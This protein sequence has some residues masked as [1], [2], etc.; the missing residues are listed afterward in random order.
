MTSG[1][2]KVWEQVSRRRQACIEFLQELVRASEGGLGRTGC[3]RSLKEEATQ[4]CVADKYR[5]LGCDVDV[6]RYDPG[7]LPIRHEFASQRLID[8]SQ[9]IAVVGTLKGAGNGRSILFWA[10]PDSSPVTGTENWVHGPFSGDVENGRLY[11]WGAADD[12]QGVAV[13]A[14][15]LEAVLAAGLEPAADLILASTPS[16]QHARGIIAVLERGHTAD[17]AVYLHPAESGMGLGDIK[18]VTSG[19][20]DFRITIPGRLPE[21]TEPG[22]AAF[23]HLAVNPI[24]KAWVVIQALQALAEK[25]AGAVHHPVLEAAIGRATNL[26]ITH[27]VC[28]DENR[29]SRISP[30]CVLAGS[31]IFPPGENGDDVQTQIVETVHRAADSDDWLRHNPPRIEW[32]R[33]VLGGTEVTTE[34]PLYRT[35]HRAIQKVTGSEPRNYPLHTGSEI[36]SPTLQK[37]IPAVGLG[38]LAGDSTQI[39]GHDEWVDVDDYITAIKV[40]ASIIMDWCGA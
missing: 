22:H 37:G 35:V 13:A 21:T 29:L 38:P 4:E 14:C 18:A 15:A 17:A 20:L 40:V 33:G 3:P 5:A 23:F 19:A 24:D 30:E 36:R 25:R 11:G 1:E 7:S 28:G 31:I 8:A 27:I 26:S 32:L 16:K 12:L 9:R 39:G 2:Q 34:H 10:H 6:I